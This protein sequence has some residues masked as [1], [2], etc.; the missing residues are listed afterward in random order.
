MEEFRTYLFSYA[1]DGARW[2]FE[3]KARDKDDAISRLN[4]IPFAA[5]DGELIANI[6]A[7]P[8]SIW[9]TISRRFC[10]LVGWPHLTCLHRR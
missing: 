2:S 3:I 5:Y 7:S 8:S 1:H 6:P 4:R 10:A 9:Q